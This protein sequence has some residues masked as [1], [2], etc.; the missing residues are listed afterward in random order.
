MLCNAPTVAYRKPGFNPV[1][2]KHYK[3]HYFYQSYK[4]LNLWQLPDHLRFEA[5]AEKYRSCPPGDEAI[6]LPC[7]HC[8]LCTRAY[9][10]MWAFRLVSEAKV[11]G[12]SMYLTLTVD[13]S[14]IDEV[15]PGGVLRHRPFQLFFKR[16]RKCLSSGYDYSFVP[17][18]TPANLIGSLP[19]TMQTRHYQCKSVKYYM[20]GEYGDLFS[21]PH[22]HCCIFGARFPDAYLQKVIGRNAYYSSPTLSKLWP[23]GFALFS[24][25]TIQS[26]SYVAGY[27]DKKLDNHYWRMKH[28]IEHPMDDITADSGSEY[29]RMSQGIGL[30]FLEKYGSRLYRFD[31]NGEVFGEFFSAGRVPIPAPKYF[32][33]KLL[34]HD[35]IKYDKIVAARER[36]RLARIA[37]MDAMDILNESGRKHAVLAARRRE[38]EVR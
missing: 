5:I 26:A 14:H 33:E 12:E 38:R 18:M 31:S 17:P 7:K 24:D 4:D 23:F 11:C 37:Q 29:V 28:F 20:C 36:R 6:L 2:G 1:T 3:P 16:L 21:R 25:V 9:R 19:R 30:S 15:F 13:D 8:L 34:L 22:Y 27:V 35:P 10:R 32:D